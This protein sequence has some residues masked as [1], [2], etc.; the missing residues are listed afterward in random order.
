[1]SVECRVEKPYTEAFEWIGTPT[2]RIYLALA[3]DPPHC[4][5]GA[6]CHRNI[7]SVSQ[8]K[9]FYEEKHTRKRGKNSHTP[10]F[11]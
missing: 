11:N 3:S 2:G 9:C 5:S 1:M 10:F 4:H 6:R 7:Q 8:E